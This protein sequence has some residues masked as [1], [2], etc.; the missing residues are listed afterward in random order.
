MKTIK[1]LI[2]SALVL[3]ILAFS[4]NSLGFAFTPAIIY[5]FCPALIFAIHVISAVALFKETKIR[6]EEGQKLFA[7]LD[8]T[9]WGLTGLTFG[10]LGLLAF[11]LLNDHFKREPNQTQ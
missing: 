2:I 8:A 1:I 9:F 5:L 11:R 3:L 10:I 6:K 7:D 4:L